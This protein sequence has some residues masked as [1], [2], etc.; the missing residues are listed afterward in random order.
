MGYKEL[1]EA[2]KEEGERIIKT[3]KAE[4]GKK[5]DII[6]GEKESRIME[7]RRGYEERY[8]AEAEK[9][10]GL[11]LREAE[12]EAIAI[13]LQAEE[14]LSRRLFRIALG[15][16]PCLRKENYGKIFEKLLKEIP[17]SDWITVKVNPED[18]MIARSYFPDAEIIK[19]P[20]ISGG[21]IVINRDGNVIINTFE[22]RLERLWPDILPDIIM[23]IKEMGDAPY[24]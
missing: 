8:N 6:E 1:I 18:V 5:A 10:R 19:D 15:L 13:R 11:I 4:A 14:E 23:K 2:I 12:K 22:K 20:S 9:R 17:E 7:I 3:L 21:L 24:R 16:I